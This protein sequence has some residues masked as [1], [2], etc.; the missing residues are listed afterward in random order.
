MKSTTQEVTMSE[1]LHPKISDADNSLKAAEKIGVGLTARSIDY[2]WEGNPR[3]DAHVILVLDGE[4]A[5]RLY[6]IL[7]AVIDADNQAFQAG[8]DAAVEAVK[9][10][11]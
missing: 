2:D 5:A 4:V 7:K 6:P 9:A 11:S 3:P 1:Q 8:E 10:S